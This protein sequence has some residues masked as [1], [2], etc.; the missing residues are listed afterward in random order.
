LDVSRAGLGERHPLFASAVRELG[1]TL[2]SAH[3]DDEAERQ[4]RR[5]LT[6]AEDVHGPRHPDVA[7]FLDALADFYVDRRRFETALTPYTRSLEIQDRFAGDVLEIGSES[8]KTASLATAPDPIPRLLKFQAVAS[9]LPAARALAFEAVTS[10]K[11]RVVEQ[12]R[13]WRQRLQESASESVRRQARDWQAMLEC[14]TSL[15]VA[16]GYR[17]LKPNLAGPCSLKG[18]EIGGRYERL[19]SDLRSRWTADL[20]TQAVQAIGLLQERAD[21][22]E[23]SLNR[24]TSGADAKPKP[25]HIEDLRRQ[26]SG[27]EALV[28]FVSY[29]DGSARAD[30]TV[31]R[32]YGAFVLSAS[33]AVNWADLGPAASIDTS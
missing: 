7:T 27:D 13:S 25:A 23:A 12:V 17:D 6:I 16:L 5:A 33:G 32:R 31:P 2:A 19:L 29:A 8:F 20:G 10:R 11:G 1:L 9:D 18:T 28:E 4:L 21:S 24:E 3:E 26:L 22:I 15:T 14:R 30:G